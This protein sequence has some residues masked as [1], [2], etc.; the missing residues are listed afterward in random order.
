MKSVIEASDTGSIQLDKKENLSHQSVKADKSEVDG[1][2]AKYV[3]F[4]LFLVYILNFVDR[5][6]LLILAENIKN[7]LGIS[8]AQLGF[9]YGTAFTVFYATFGIAFGRL[10][11]TWN[12]IKL[13]SLGLGVW[14]LMTALS[15][16]SRSFLPLAACR[17]GVGVGEASASPAAYSILYDYF[18]PRVRTTVLALYSCGL[19]I[20]GG[21]GLFLGGAI[22]DAWSS[23]WPDAGLAPFGL[24]GWQAAFMIVGLPGLLM[25]LW[26]STLKEPVRGQGDG[27]IS[28]PHSHPFRETLTVLISMFPITNLWLFA[29]S[30]KGRKV[31]PLNLTA[32]VFIT[33]LA[34]SLIQITGSIEQWVALGIAIYAVTSWAQM[35]A[36]RD[37][38]VFGMIFRCKALLYAVFGVSVVLLGTG[39]AGFWAIPFLQRYHGL[40]IADVGTI[41]GLGGI[42]V[43]LVGII[44]GGMLA[45]KLRTRTAKGKLYVVLGAL[46]LGG[47]SLFIVFTVG[48]LPVVYGAYFLF[49]F[50]LSMFVGPIASTINDLVLPRAR[51]S[52]IAFYF[53]LAG[54]AGGAL[55]PYIVGYISDLMATTGVDSGEALRQSALWC[56]LPVI[57]GLAI[58]CLAL[59]HIETDEASVVDR[60]RRLGEEV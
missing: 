12:R 42:V 13:I 54:L 6:L 25:T 29:R 56:M 4:V 31:M 30:A 55:G 40:N 33:L 21:M 51:A 14:S 15:G 5:Q 10:A 48:Y 20:G 53:M 34:I 46:A 19:V 3:L 43:G 58:I 59:R 37:P 16:L 45:D 36:V 49:S 60:A 57:P 11:D 9:L 2:Y 44:F 24:K 32:G 50:G 1:P 35:L 23:T 7:D 39:G 47:L 41:L 8:D 22:V 26:V 27:I 38:V 28:K 17:F 18:S 52:S